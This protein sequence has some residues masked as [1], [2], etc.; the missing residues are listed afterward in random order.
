LIISPVLQQWKE[1]Q[2]ARKAAASTGAVGAADILTGF[3]TLATALCA[4]AH[5]PTPPPYLFMLHNIGIPP[6]SLSLLPIAGTAGPSLTLED[7]CSQYQVD[8]AVHQKLFDEGY[9]TSHH[10]QYVTVLE[11]KEAGFRIGEITSLKDAFAC[12]SIPLD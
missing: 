12:W 1:A 2:E 4:P 3:A 5:A 9:K 8:L 11:L 10:L 7:F 6:A